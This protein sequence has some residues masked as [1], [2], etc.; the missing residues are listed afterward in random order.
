M[1]KSRSGGDEVLSAAAIRGK[2]ASARRGRPAFARLHRRGLPI[3][4]V[5][6]TEVAR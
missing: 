2:A 5:N 4:S 1:G 3:E 6:E